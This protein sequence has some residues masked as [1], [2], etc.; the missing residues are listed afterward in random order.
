M[1]LGS[2]A[3]RAGRPLAR[4][5]MPVLARPAPDRIVEEADASRVHGEAQSGHGDGL[6]E[7]DR[8]RCGHLYE[9]R[10]RQVHGRH[11]EPH[12]A[13]ESP[14]RPDLP[15]PKQYRSERAFLRACA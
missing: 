13:R 7:L 11:R 3:A 12:R 14:E 8:R 1:V 6:V 2:A 10:H 9:A 4:M 5:G 15:V